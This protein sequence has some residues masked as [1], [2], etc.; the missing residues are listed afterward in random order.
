MDNLLKL[1]GA[2]AFFAVLPHA[3]AM[4]A[5][6][7][8]FMKNKSSDGRPMQFEPA[9]IKIAAGDSVTFVPEDAGH[10]VEVITNLSP[11]GTQEWVGSLNQELTITFSAEGFHVYKCPPHFDMGMIGLIQV[12][13]MANGVDPVEAAKLPGKAKSRLKALLADAGVTLSN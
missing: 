9:F 3:G 11:K 6:Y 4:A 7:K 5:D 2:A 13:D 1:V 8:V 12:G 10:N